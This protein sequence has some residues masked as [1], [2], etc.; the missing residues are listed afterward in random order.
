MSMNRCTVGM[1]VNASNNIDYIVFS[2]TILSMHVEA[3]FPI[4]SDFHLVAYV[5]VMIYR[6]II[7]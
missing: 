4:G 7:A 2:L 5:N 3:F 6:S 1:D